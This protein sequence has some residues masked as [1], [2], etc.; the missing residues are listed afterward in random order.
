[1]TPLHY[2]IKQGEML[3]IVAIKVK[4]HHVGIALWIWFK[5]GTPLLSGASSSL[6]NHI[7]TV[8]LNSDAWTYLEDDPA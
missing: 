2:K 8:S 5:M 7:W 6:S 4:V 1:M 3:E